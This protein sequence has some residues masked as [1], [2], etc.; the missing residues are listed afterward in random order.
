MLPV[1][2]NRTGRPGSSTPGAL[3]AAACSVPEPGVRASRRRVPDPASA[4]TSA[5]NRPPLTVRVRLPP[6]SRVPRLVRVAPPAWL[7]DSYQVTLQ[8]VLLAMLVLAGLG[9]RWSYGWRWESILAVLAVMWIPVP[10]ILGHA[11]GL[12]GP[13]LPLDGVLL[14]FAAFAAA[15]C[16]PGVNGPLLDAPDA[17]EP[18]P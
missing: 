12:S 6:V 2:S 17:G 4:P 9:W 3:P 8:A 18:Q 15:R 13:R 14:C 11:E 5:L 7:M 1:I 10:Y 16:V